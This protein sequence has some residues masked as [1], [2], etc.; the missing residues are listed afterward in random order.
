MSVALT[1]SHRSGKSTLAKDFAKAIG[2]VY[3]PSR[4][5]QMFSDMGLVVG[6][7]L[8]F[9]ECMN[10]QE[11]ILEAHLADVRGA[12]G[13]FVCDRSTIDMA[14]YTMIEWGQ[15]ANPQQSERLLAYVDRCLTQASWLYSC[16]MLIQPGIP[17][18][19]EPGKPPPSP[20]FQELF[21]SLCFSYL[22]D[23]RMSSQIFYMRRVT[24]SHEDRMHTMSMVW[25][26][27]CAN[28]PTVKDPSIIM[29]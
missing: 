27:V 3:L 9:T 14:V 17:F 5:G 13:I 7:E 23:P 26:H 22:R 28:H 15:H 20:S 8:T 24:L 21:N 10:V 4:A 6:Q 16:I 29:H 25:K 1:G 18:V 11:A 19:I 12:D 2:G